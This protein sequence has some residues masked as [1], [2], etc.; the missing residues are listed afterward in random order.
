M[1]RVDDLLQMMIEAVVSL[2]ARNEEEFI[3]KFGESTTSSNEGKR[4]RSLKWCDL[5]VGERKV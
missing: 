5:R 3:G 4:M 1:T 2:Q